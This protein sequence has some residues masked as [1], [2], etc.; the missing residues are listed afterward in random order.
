[1]GKFQ[2]SAGASGCGEQAVVVAN[3]H[4]ILIYAQVGAQWEEFLQGLL[5]G[6]TWDEYPCKCLIFR[7]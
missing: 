6:E 4:F 5:G 7:H 3:S 2:L 1:M